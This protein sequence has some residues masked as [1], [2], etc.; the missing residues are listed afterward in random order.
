MIHGPGCSER[1]LSCCANGPCKYNF[2]HGYQEETILGNDNYPL[3]CHMCPEDRGKTFGKYVNNVKYVVTSGDVAVFSP[4][5]LKKFDCHI[6]VEYGHTVKFIKYLF[7]H[8]TKGSD[9]AN[10]TLKK[11]SSES[12]QEQGDKKS[13]HPEMKLRSTKHGDM[14]AQ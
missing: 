14:S 1:C 5:L 7:K 13:P 8:I 4:W 2:P 11:E 9:Q 3:Y 10:I 12:P 6:N